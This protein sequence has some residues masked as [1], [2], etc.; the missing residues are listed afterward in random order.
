MKIS[1]SHSSYSTRETLLTGM[2][3][4]TKGKAPVVDIHIKTDPQNSM[5]RGLNWPET[6][7]LPK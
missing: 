5:L 6:S 3:E 7:T 4:G 2:T 1:Y